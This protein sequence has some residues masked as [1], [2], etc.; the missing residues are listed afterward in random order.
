MTL[1]TVVTRVVLA[2]LASSAG[3]GALLSAQ[4][5]PAKTNGRL[6]RFGYYKV[7]DKSGNYSDAVSGYTNIVVA[8]PKNAADTD[9]PDWQTPLRAQIQRA[10]S[11]GKQI[12]L[13]VEVPDLVQN[14][15]V[16]T[17]AGALEAAKPYW[18]NVAI[19]SFR[20]DVDGGILRGTL[21]TEIQQVKNALDLKGMA[22]KPFMAEFTLSGVNSDAVYASGLNIV[23]FEAYLCTN[24]GDPNDNV[25]TMREN[26]A[27]AKSRVR[28]A[29]KDMML[30]LM[31]FTPT[32]CASWWTYNRISLEAMQD[33]TYAEAYASE[34]GTNPV[35]GISIFAYDRPDA[36]ID[37][38]QLAMHHRRM[39][40][41][42]KPDGLP[43]MTDGAA[44]RGCS[45]YVERSPVFKPSA[46]EC[47]DYCTANNA[48]ACEYLNGNCYVEY[49][50]GCYLEGGHGGWQAVVLNSDQMEGASAIRGCDWWTW[51]APVYQPNPTACLAYCQQNG[52]NMCEYGDGT[53]ECY[54][55]F[56]SNCKIT[57]L[58][59]WHATVLTPVYTK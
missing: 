8:D 4:A 14:R 2:V 31:A 45:E 54:V 52:A 49:G 10:A 24:G 27:T 17:L 38:G 33:A 51:W 22:Y 21:E 5:L 18:D 53:G 1:R 59:G 7:D 9:Q 32:G 23:G 25:T 15:Q 55:E 36:T 44:V 46:S 26:I 42:I 3:A 37:H 40:A 28:G 56:G 6:I 29:G 58:G 57:T 34:G 35:I 30:T 11:A 12:L 43:L 50:N 47:R 20:D 41:M 48:D 16:I 13:L 39:S 19:V